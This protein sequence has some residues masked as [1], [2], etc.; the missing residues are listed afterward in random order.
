MA[1]EELL[2]PRERPTAADALQATAPQSIRRS[3]HKNPIS[4]TPSAT[5]AAVTFNQADRIA[6]VTG[7][8]KRKRE[9]REVRSTR[10]RALSGFSIHRLHRTKCISR[11]CGK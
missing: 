8:A 3:K 9:R 4:S 11:S 5:T 2:V 7:F 6:Y 1:E 10:S